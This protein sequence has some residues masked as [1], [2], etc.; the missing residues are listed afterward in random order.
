MSPRIDTFLHKMD[1]QHWLRLLVC[2]GP[3][4]ILAKIG[5]Y[6]SAST[7]WKIIGSVGLAA[8]FAVYVFWGKIRRQ[9]VAPPPADDEVNEELE[10]QDL[11]SVSVREQL[12]LLRELNALCSGDSTH[13]IELLETEAQLHPEW[14][15]SAVI[16]E[17]HH[18]RAFAARTR[19]GS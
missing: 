14:S 3:A 11:E 12:E 8:G 16:A 1:K 13:A 9:L 18:R 10:R 15:M 6:P 5:A 19:S 7:L 4:L 2:L 17:A